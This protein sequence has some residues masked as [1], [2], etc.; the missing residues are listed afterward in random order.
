MP[1]NKHAEKVSAC[2]ALWVVALNVYVAFARIADGNCGESKTLLTASIYP[3]H[4]TRLRMRFS[5]T[6]FERIH[7][8]FYKSKYYT[9]HQ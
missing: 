1:T 3:D 2:T 4:L 5:G 6:E 7:Y 9:R 8:I